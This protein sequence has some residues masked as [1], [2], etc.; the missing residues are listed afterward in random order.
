VS[1]RVSSILIVFALAAVSAG[2]CGKGAQAKPDGGD[3]S[4]TTTPDA[5]SIPD[6]LSGARHAFDVTAAL[7][8][9][10]GVTGS[11]LPATNSFTLVLDA[12]ARLAI[13]GGN[14][15]GAVVAVA[16]DDGRT[17]RSTAPFTVGAPI[18]DGCSGPEDVTYSGFDVTIAGGSLTGTA[19]GNA[20][21]SCGDCIFVVAFTAKL[22]GRA[23]ATA[24]TLRASA[25]LPTTPFDPIAV[26]A[27]EPLPSTATARLV[28]DDG[29]AIDLM[30]TAMDGALPLIVGFTKPD[31]VLRAGQGYVVTLDGLVDFAGHVP[32]AD[33]PL[34]LTSFPAAPVVAEDGFESATGSTLGGAMVMTAGALPAIAGNTSLYIG[35][36]G[37]PGLDASNGRS[38]S[39]KLARKAGDTAL[40][41]SYRVVAASAQPVFQ[42]AFRIGSEG[43]PAGTLVYG[44]GN[45][46][47]TTEMLTVAGKAAYASPVAQN[48]VPLPADT[49]GEVLFVIEPSSTTCFRG[50]LGA[51]GLLI[52]DLRLE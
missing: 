1:G 47:G 18:A 40:R 38:L 3:G 37:A 14:G 50:G 28:A 24:P 4:L 16:T 19:T 48:D 5:T 41:F 9:T 49:T 30:P 21:I 2:G 13:A 42:G 45:P 33:P 51:T 11:G 32:P 12:D 34:R 25:F 17:Y 22:S 27:S 36:P 44:I 15:R 35:G 6:A 26:L 10:G 43:G 39:V 23:D 7:H 31:V 20:S 29:A 46:Q 8:A 52:D